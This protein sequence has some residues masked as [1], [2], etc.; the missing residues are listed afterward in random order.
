MKTTL[1]K[2]LWKKE[3]KHWNRTA[4]IFKKYQSYASRYTFG[5]IIAIIG[6]IFHYGF[7]IMHT[8][9]ELFLYIC[10]RKAFRANLQRLALK[11]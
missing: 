8:L 10:F 7:A 1:L 6:T 5:L 3:I 9:Y 4:G 11:I 2:I